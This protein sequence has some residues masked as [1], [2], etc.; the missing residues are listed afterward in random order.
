MMSGRPAFVLSSFAVLSAPQQALRCPN[1]MRSERVVM[2]SAEESSQSA[3]IQHD[4]LREYGMATKLIKGGHAP[5][6]W[7]SDEYGRSVVN[8]PVYHASTVTFPNVEALNHANKS[9]LSGWYYGRFGQPTSW[10]LEEAF[11]VIE[12]AYKACAVGSGVAAANASILAFVQGGDHVLV[13]DGV[14]GPTR[15]FCDKFLKRFFV[16]VTYYSP[17]ASAEELRTLFISKK[18]KVLFCES[19]SSLSFEVQDLRAFCKVAHE[20]G[21]KVIADNTYGPTLYQP[22]ALGADVSYNAATKYIGG[23]SDIVM[24]LI[25]CTKQT[26]TAV[27]R[28]VA[29]LGC[30]PGPDD[31]YLALRGLRT[32]GVRIK[33]H[34]KNGLQVAQWLESR[35][36]VVRVIHPGLRSHPQHALFKRDFS[37]SN[38]L[39]T[40]QLHARYSQDDANRFINGLTLFTLGFSWGGFESL[41]LQCRINSSRRVSKFVYDEHTF[42]ITLRLHVGL[43]DPQDLIHDLLAAFD[44]LNGRE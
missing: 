28:S 26:Y 15:S 20:F 22:L 37:G 17:T 13:S 35:P 30:P 6:L 9:P 43:E 5:Y 8:P 41:I 11:A 32:L 23:H 31:C 21:A 25:A 39:F 38:G 7:T 44:C 34:E 24:G 14:Y 33:Q 10:A 40:F 27:K 19:P 12:G 16:E 4:A 3:E 1:G 36:E 18:T 29:M 2:T 42:G